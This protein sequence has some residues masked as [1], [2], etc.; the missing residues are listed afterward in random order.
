M[1][2]APQ[3]TRETNNEAAAALSAVSLTPATAEG[4]PYY[5]TVTSVD[6]EWLSQFRLSG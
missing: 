1:S 3:A 5:A 2:A 4:I 6:D